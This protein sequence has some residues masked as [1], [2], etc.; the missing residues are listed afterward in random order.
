MLSMIAPPWTHAGGEAG[1]AKSAAPPFHPCGRLARNELSLAVALRLDLDAPRLHAFLQRQRQSQHA[2]A[3]RRTQLVEIQE[4]RNGKGL[5]VARHAR[6]FVAGV[7]FGADAER[8][9][10][11]VEVDVFGVDAR[12]GDVNLPAVFAGIDLEGR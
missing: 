12:D 3:M 5:F 11:D 2:V 8:V 10:G 6:P 7:A 4:R 1:G 9:A